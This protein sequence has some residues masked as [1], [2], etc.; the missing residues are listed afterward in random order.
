MRDS[1]DPDKFRTF[2]TYPISV[3]YDSDNLHKSRK[4]QRKVLM[5]AIYPRH[6]T[7]AKSK[8]REN[9]KRDAIV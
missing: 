6:G 8:H 3:S 4:D 1:E 7:G 5:V 9:C 2:L